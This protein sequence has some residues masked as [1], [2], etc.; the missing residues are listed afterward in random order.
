MRFGS[1]PPLALAQDMKGTFQLKRFE[2]GSDA[3]RIVLPGTV[4]QTATFQLKR[5]LAATTPAVRLIVKMLYT[6][7][8]KRR[9]SDRRR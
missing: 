2:T 5:F 6:F 1:G 9:R 3:A 8:L 7:Q 4:P